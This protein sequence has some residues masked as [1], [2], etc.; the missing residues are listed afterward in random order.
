MRNIPD[1]GH[2]GFQVDTAAVTKPTTAA[3]TETTGNR[4]TPTVVDC[5]GHELVLQRVAHRLE[6]VPL[7]L[8]RLV[9]RGH[10]RPRLQPLLLVEVGL[11]DLCYQAEKRKKAVCEDSFTRVPQQSARQGPPTGQARD[12]AIGR[13]IMHDL[14]FNT[15]LTCRTET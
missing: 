4:N 6:P 2:N 7:R 1:R 10:H 14:E 8:Q 12:Q 9:D 11:L 3:A 13:P 15:S 5:L